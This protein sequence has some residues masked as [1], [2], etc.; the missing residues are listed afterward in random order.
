MTRV[1]AGPQQQT[2]VSPHP[3]PVAGSTVWVRLAECRSGLPSEEVCRVVDAPLPVE[4]RAGGPQPR[5]TGRQR[6]RA[7]G[8]RAT[9]GPAGAEG[10]GGTGGGTQG[11][12]A[13]RGCRQ[14]Q[15]AGWTVSF[16]TNLPLFLLWEGVRPIL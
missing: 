2:Q 10:A 11:R 8:S 3:K 1:G 15:Q 14:A 16:L 6:G 5:D 9:E 13:S 12:A 7:V 4:K